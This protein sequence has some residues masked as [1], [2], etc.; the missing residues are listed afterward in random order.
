MCTTSSG[1][2]QGQLAGVGWWWEGDLSH[3]SFRHSHLFLDFG[4]QL[5]VIELFIFQFQRQPDEGRRGKRGTFSHFSSP[6]LSVLRSAEGVGLL[7]SPH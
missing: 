6:V 2:R 1:P 7:F 3:R 5:P 4:L